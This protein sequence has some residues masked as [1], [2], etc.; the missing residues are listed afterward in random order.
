MKRF[1]ILILCSFILTA[2]VGCNSGV[3]EENATYE[4]YYMTGDFAEGLTPY[5]AALCNKL[6]SLFYI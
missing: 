6:L 2:F 3:S 5:I 1:F 4:I